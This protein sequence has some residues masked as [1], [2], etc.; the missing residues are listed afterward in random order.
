MQKSAHFRVDPKL[1]HVL[2]ESYTTSEKALKELVDNVW[3]AEATEV[4]VTVPNILTDSPII[5][6]NNGSGMKTTEFEA[7]YQNQM[8]KHSLISQKPGVGLY[9]PCNRRAPRSERRGAV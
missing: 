7:E 1:A 4:H 3:D 6:Q 8:R 5:V 9:L 2:G